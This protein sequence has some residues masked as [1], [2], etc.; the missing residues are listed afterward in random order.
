MNIRNNVVYLLIGQRGSG[1]SHFAKAAVE[2]NNHLSIVSRDEILIRLFGSADINPYCGGHIKAEEIMWRLLRRKLSTQSNLKMFLDFWTGG[3]YERHHTI[4]M[5]RSYGAVKVI[6]LYFVTP[7]NLVDEWFWKKPGI[8]KSS[9]RAK[10]S[11]EKGIGFFSENAP[12]H[13]YELFH[14]LAKDID[15]DGFYQVIRVDPLN[16]PVIQ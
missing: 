13:D 16:P 9:E 11:G 7:L 1:K 2:K 10:R 3:K 5:L 6:A 4:R 8:A 15:S 14:E 12:K